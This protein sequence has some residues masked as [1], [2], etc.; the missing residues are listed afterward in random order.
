MPARKPSA[1]EPT[2]RITGRGNIGSRFTLGGEWNAH[3]T[4]HDPRRDDGRA[5][6]G[7]VDHYQALPDPDRF[8]LPEGE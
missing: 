5:F 7:D 8:V 2:V 4:D 1:P 6:E 3:P